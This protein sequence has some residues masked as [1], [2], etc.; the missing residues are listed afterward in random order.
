MTNIISLKKTPPTE[1]VTLANMIVAV[2]RTALENVA[3]IG[4]LVTAAAEANIASGFSAPR[5]QPIFDDI[6]QMSALQFDQL[7]AITATHQ[8]LNKVGQDILADESSY[9][10]GPD[11]S[12]MVLRLAAMADRQSA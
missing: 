3:A 9:P 12:C 8:K 6:R 4:R 11:E 10:W 5:T 1:M 7:T 2:E